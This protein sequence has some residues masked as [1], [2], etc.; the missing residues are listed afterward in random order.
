MSSTARIRGLLVPR[1]DHEQKNFRA[2]SCGLM[3]R[4]YLL[5]IG[6]KTRPDQARNYSTTNAHEHEN[7]FKVQSDYDTQLN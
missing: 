1:R 7:E 2:R 4:S 6:L 5:M 3:E